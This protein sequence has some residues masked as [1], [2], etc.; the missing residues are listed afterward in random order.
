MLDD[1]RLP[2]L[3]Q[4]MRSPSFFVKLFLVKSIWRS[5]LIN[6]YCV[7]FL[8]YFLK[9]LCLILPEAL[10]PWPIRPIHG[11]VLSAKNNL[12]LCKRFFYLEN[13]DYRK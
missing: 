2:I 9:S 10:G 6:L 4:C 12:C 13:S 3:C 1:H 11:P 7:Y 5:K 8:L